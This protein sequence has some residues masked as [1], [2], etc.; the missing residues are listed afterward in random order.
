M[1][2]NGS[3][4]GVRIGAVKGRSQVLN[5]RVGWTKRNTTNGR[6]MDVKQDG[7]AFKGVRK[8]NDRS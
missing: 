3:K 8:E 6:F 5:P 2:K 4:G 1:A 7:T